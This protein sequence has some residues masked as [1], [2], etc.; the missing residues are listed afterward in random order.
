MSNK[1]IV[2]LDVETAAQAR[3]LVARVRDHV[4]MFKVGSQLFT[5]VGPEIVRE[6]VGD[7]GRVFLDLKFH[8]IPNTVASA[9]R[10]AVRLGVSI[11]NVHAF[12]GREM[13][14]RAA[15]SATETAEREGLERPNVIAVTVLTSF[16]SATLG[17]LGIT[18]TP[19]A[20]ATL[21]ARLAST[22]GLDG[23]VASAHE[24]KQV[25]SVV[26][27]DGFLVVTPGV[28]QRAVANDDQRRI[29]SPAEAVRAGADYVVMGRAIIDAPD[30]VVAAREASEEIERACVASGD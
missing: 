3:E 15:E 26:M 5:A 14:R 22:C 1:L 27:R 24:I 10:E 2:A 8:D 25:R 9:A 13:M 20:Q 30:P 23:V 17:D 4:G 28:R 7:G 12:G 21:L 18:F 6:I 11:F 16:D 19:E 29:M